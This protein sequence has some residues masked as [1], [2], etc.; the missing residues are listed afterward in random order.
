MQAVIVVDPG[1]ELSAG[2]TGGVKLVRV[3]LVVLFGNG[4]V[5]GQG[6][7][8]GGPADRDAN[9]CFG[10]EIG[11]VFV[12]VR[13]LVEVD[14][15]EEGEPRARVWGGPVNEFERGGEFPIDFGLDLVGR[16]A[17][18]LDGVEPEVPWHL[19]LGEV[20]PR[21]GTHCGPC[22]LGEA[23][24]GLS[25]G[26]SP[27]DFGLLAVDPSAGFTPQELLVAVATELF[28]KCSGVCAELLKG[29]NNARRNQ[30]LHFVEPQ[31]LGCAVNEQDGVAKPKFADGV[32]EDYVEMDF[33]QVVLGRR[34]GLSTVAFADVGKFPDGG[35]WFAAFDE[36]G[37]LGRLAEMFVIPKPSVSKK[38]VYLVGG[39]VL[40]RV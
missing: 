32:A 36:L 28:G 18:V 37:I 6:V 8:L 3:R 5:D 39:E 12:T 38:M 1:G 16:P 30:R 15:R 40:Q 20:C 24:G 29:F 17:R 2:E 19:C 26:G 11:A 27:D 10:L 31:V 13:V 4:V 7:G 33:V 22:A 23:V 9:H 21:H 25:A 35:A 14:A 34:E